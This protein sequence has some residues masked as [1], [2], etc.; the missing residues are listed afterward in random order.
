MCVC[1]CGGALCVISA[2]PPSSS[3]L[4]YER[5]YRLRRNSAL[6]HGVHLTDISYLSDMLCWFQ[7]LHPDLP[8]AVVDIFGM[9]EVEITATDDPKSKERFYWIIKSVEGVCAR[10]FTD[11]IIRHKPAKSQL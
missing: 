5:S 10:V 9:L 8:A 4:V 11:L 6:K 2:A 3:V 1:V 7:A